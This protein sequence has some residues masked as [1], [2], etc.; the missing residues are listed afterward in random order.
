MCSQQ[1]D[2]T[3][4]TILQQDGP[5]HLGLWYNAAPRASNRPNHLGLCAR[6]G[7]SVLVL[8]VAQ[9]QAFNGTGDRR[10]DCHSAAP[11]STFSRCFNRD[12]EGMS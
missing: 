2:P 10:R 4:R 11:P 5:N 1:R 9:D 12:G 3:A 6:S 8:K 7:P